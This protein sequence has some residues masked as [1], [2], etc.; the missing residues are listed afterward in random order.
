MSK[1]LLLTLATALS[2]VAQNAQLRGLV[3]DPSGSAVPGA[4]IVIT[5]TATGVVRESVSNGQGVYRLPLLPPGKYTMQ[6]TKDGFKSIQQREIVLQ[7]DDLVT[8]DIHLEVGAQ[9]QSVSVVAEMPLLRKDDAQTGL[10]IDNKRIQELPQYNRNALAFAQ[11][12]PN[13]NGTAD[14]QGYST[15]FRINGGRTAKA[16]YIIDG[17]AVTTGFRHDVPPSIPSMEAVG[18]FKVITNGLSA[19]YGRLSGG[20]VTLVTRS[21]T[22]TYH[23]SVY[24]FLRNDKLNSNDWNSNRFGRAKGV[25][26]DNVFGGAF[27]GPVWIPKLYKGKDRTF[28]FLNYEGTRRRTGSNAQLAGVPSDLERD[29]DFSRSLIDTELPSRLSTTPGTS[30]R[31]SCGLRPSVGRLNTCRFSIVPDSVPFSVSSSGVCA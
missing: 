9:S 13:V 2:L 24:E 7:I 23:G 1:H 28:F 5:N 3:S 27:G 26:H 25:F 11:L 20:A 21:G 19:E 22:N 16:E 29:G 6:V 18:E 31:K 4:G 14:Q 15:D 12:A 8:L 30:K 10:V 17:V